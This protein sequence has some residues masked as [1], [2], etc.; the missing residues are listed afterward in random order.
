[1]T[2]CNTN[3]DTKTVRQQIILS[4]AAGSASAWIRKSPMQYFPAT[5][6]VLRGTMGIVYLLILRIYADVVIASK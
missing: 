2:F 6:L 3:L 4:Y 5:L 1:M